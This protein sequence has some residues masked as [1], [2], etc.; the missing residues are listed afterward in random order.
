MAWGQLGGSIEALGEG[1]GGVILSPV[2]RNF[3]IA[4]SFP[5]GHAAHT[6]NLMRSCLVPLV[7]LLT[8]Y[9]AFALTSGEELALQA[10]LRDI[11]ALNETS[12]PWTLDTSKACSALG[13]YGVECSNGT[14]PH[15]IGMYVTNQFIR[16]FHLHLASSYVTS[17]P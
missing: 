8:V 12:P 7:L 17:M 14:D 11:P 9:G 3:S 15:I 5:P 16:P 10:F 1:R 13:F 2:R 4:D 6:S